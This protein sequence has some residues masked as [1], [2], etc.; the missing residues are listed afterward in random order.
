MRSGVAPTPLRFLHHHNQ[1][2]E[3]TLIF[4]LERLQHKLYTR[5]RKKTTLVVH[6]GAV[7]VLA[8]KYRNFTSDVDFIERVLPEELDIPQKGSRSGLFGK[9]LAVGGKTQDT[10]TALRECI[11]ETA[12]EF[13]KLPANVRK[14]IELEED[15]MNSDAD[16]ALPWK[17]E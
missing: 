3:K 1:L 16:V 15:W 17:L 9:I 5:R 7:A 4:L 6:G 8:L 12:A 14:N 11:A 13:N 2:D 10:R